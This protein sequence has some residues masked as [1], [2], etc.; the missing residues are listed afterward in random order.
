MGCAVLHCD[1]LAWQG[2]DIGLGGQDLPRRDV[3]T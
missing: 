2:A 3:L 1:P